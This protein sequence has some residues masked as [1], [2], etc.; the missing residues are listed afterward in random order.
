MLKKIL[1]F[2]VLIVSILSAQETRGTL[3]GNAQ[4]TD[5]DGKQYDLYDV[6]ASGKHVLLHFSFKN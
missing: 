1:L 3:S 4:F 6:L 5:T 2:S